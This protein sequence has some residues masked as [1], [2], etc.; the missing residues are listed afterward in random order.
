MMS[1]NHH[2]FGTIDTFFYRRLAGIQFN[3]KRSGDVVIDP[4][5]VRGINT[6][7]AEFCGIR[8]SYDADVL[9]VESPC[10]FTLHRNGART[11]HGPGVY[12]FPRA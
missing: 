4:L 3:D 1:L 11:Q 2:F 12:A 9:R 8:V 10:A 7:S 5:F 6:L